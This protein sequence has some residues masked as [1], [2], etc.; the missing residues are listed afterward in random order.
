M[1]IRLFIVTPVYN[2]LENTLNFVH[3]LLPLL[4]P[5]ARLVVIDNG[6]TDGT[7]DAV[8]C[9]YPE[10]TVLNGSSDLLWTGA[11]N[12][13]IRHALEENADYVLF[14]NNDAILHPDFLNELLLAS[15]EYPNAIISPKIL[16]ADEPW[17]IW[18]MG[19]KVDWLRGSHGLIGHNT[20]DDEHWNEP[21]EVDWL[22]GMAMLAPA[23]IFHQGILPDER[24]FPHY[25]S[26]SDFCLRAKKAGF[27]MI[28]WPQSRVYN[29][30]KSS[31]IVEKFL[32]EV[33]PF[34]LRRFIQMLTSNRS[35]AAFCTFGRFVIRHAPVWSWPLTF[36]RF[37]GFFF[38]KYIQ[39]AL[40]LPRP[41]QWLKRKNISEFKN[42]WNDNE[43]CEKEVADDFV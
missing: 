23:R 27:K 17:R 28:T 1:D 37:Y 26:D 3:N 34:S 25:T 11:I 8:R 30:E 41:R 9:E 39:I 15:E 7:G 4:P 24:A 42:K 12:I 35:S 19:G 38:L 18:S 14:L 6:S 22:V 20:P 13:G 32:L 36:T 10:V 16:S 40:H 31:G 43:R 21:L 29:K 5:A 33:E 2:D